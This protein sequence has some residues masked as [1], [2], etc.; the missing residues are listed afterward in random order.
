MEISQEPLE[1]Y[2]QRCFHQSRIDVGL[3]STDLPEDVIIDGN[4]IPFNEDCVNVY[5]IGI[6]VR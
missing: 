3:E 1:Q 4:K 5:L 6:V 2:A